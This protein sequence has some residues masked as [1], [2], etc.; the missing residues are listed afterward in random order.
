MTEAVTEDE[1]W[2]LDRGLGVQTEQVERGLF[3]THLVDP[4]GRRRIA[5][6][7]GRGTTCD[8]SVARARRRYEIQQLGP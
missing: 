4:E 1:Q 6:D 3:W 2:F 7:Y 8:E 5:P